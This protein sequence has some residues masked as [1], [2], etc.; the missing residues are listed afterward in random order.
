MYFLNSSLTTLFWAFDIWVLQSP[1]CYVYIYM[2]SYSRIFGKF[3]LYLRS[4]FSYGTYSW[5][6]GILVSLQCKNLFIL[7]PIDHVTME[8]C[9]WGSYC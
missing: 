4:V 6:V 9:P 5:A 7:A 3:L 1:W 2:Y 8:R